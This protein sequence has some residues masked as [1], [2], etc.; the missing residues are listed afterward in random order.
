MS[1]PTATREF[2]VG[3][4]FHENALN[5]ISTQ[6]HAQNPGLFE[7]RQEIEINKES[8]RK[9]VL[10]LIIDRPIAFNFSPL[11]QG[12]TQL[13]RIFVEAHIVF[14]LT[15]S[16]PAGGGMGLITRFRATLSA[17][18]KLV[19]RKVGLGLDIERLTVDEFEGDHPHPFSSL[20]KGIEGDLS[21]DE[22]ISGIEIEG[23]ADAAFESTNEAFIALLNYVTVVFLDGG[24]RRFVEEIKLPAIELLP[25]LG[26]SLH[27]R[28]LQVFSDRIGLYA[29]LNSG[30]I[31][32]PRS[33]LPAARRDL[34]H[35]SFGI[36][37]KTVSTVLQKLLPITTII[38][39]TPPDKI[40][41]I[42]NGSSFSLLKNSEIDLE[43]PDLIKTRLYFTARINAQINVNLS[44]WKI[45]LPIVLPIGA[46]SHFR[47]RLNPFIRKDAGS[48]EFVVS[49]R[50]ERD[51][52]SA[53]WILIVTNY[54]ELI[55]EE[56]KGWLRRHVS[57]VLRKIPL[58]GWIIAK[59]VEEIVGEIAGAAGWFLDFAAS[60]TLT[61]LLN[62]G[63]HAFRLFSNDSLDF[64]LVKIPSEFEGL[65]IP[66]GIES[67]KIAGVH[68]NQGG[69]LV[70]DT[71]LDKAHNP[72]P[73]PPVPIPEPD[74]NEPPTP[75][76]PKPPGEEPDGSFRPIFGEVRSPYPSS[77]QLNYEILTK[78]A[79]GSERSIMTI[80]A[81]TDT[82]GALTAE[83]SKAVTFDFLEPDLHT[84]LKLSD[85][86]LLLSEVTRQKISQPGGSDSTDFVTQIEYRPTN[87]TLD[88]SAQIGSLPPT[89]YSRGYPVGS[90]PVP[91]DFWPVSLM[92]RNFTKGDK[93]V[94]AFPE[95]DF[96][97]AGA[98]MIRFT[99]IAFE[100]NAEIDV[101][102]GTD[103]VKCV[104]LKG[105]DPNR[106][107]YSIFVEVAG[108]K[109]V[110]RVT[111]KSNDTEIAMHLSV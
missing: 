20:E 79:A 55:K 94:L 51:F 2:D 12:D 68:P 4:E 15:D 7:L 72:V 47:G 69:E 99:P 96:S 106:T 41:S 19:P 93:F 36:T 9:L 97:Q 86:G 23:A 1:F 110:V 64:E 95:W 90:Y 102:V 75:P 35:L 45:H 92:N 81:G 42:G 85:R 76:L 67:A 58:I 8:G 11:K 91:T 25:D 103:P 32:E 53:Q 39:P 88:A 98:G 40:F 100:A 61:S 65:G 10:Y 73:E 21:I 89:G 111:A 83:V 60:V 34:P 44:G 13:N 33:P 14:T 71:W 38:E 28:A 82:S 59:G 84:K 63:Y 52:F 18:C 62:V 27:T 22:L 54:R 101:L 80:K 57:P 74:P 17:I 50:P 6:A 105:T 24:M 46:P 87:Y 104:E 109:R 78:T 30:G 49:L 29:A 70:L 107:S 26:V 108:A 16:L 31:S 37:E 43:A 66:I 5:L 77:I 56:V 48:K 3:I